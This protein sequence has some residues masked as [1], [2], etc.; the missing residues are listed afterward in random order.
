MKVALVTCKRHWYISDPVSGCQDPELG[1]Y[2][3]GEVSA[4]KKL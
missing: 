2:K 1:K 3:V 4:L